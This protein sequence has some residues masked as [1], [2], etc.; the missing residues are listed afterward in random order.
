[1]QIPSFLH[2]SGVGKG[3]QGMNFAVISL[4]IGLL[5]HL[6]HGIYGLVALELSPQ[7]W[8][9]FGGAKNC[10]GSVVKRQL[11]ASICIPPSGIPHNAI[12]L[13]DRL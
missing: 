8:R 7:I 11:P 5:R 10:Y 4:E 3:N 13:E 12:I 6:P 2:G 1:M 9:S